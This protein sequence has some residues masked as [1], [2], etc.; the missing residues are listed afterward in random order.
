[1]QMLIY[2][3]IQST[4]HQRQRQLW[5]SALRILMCIFRRM[6]T[7]IRHN[8]AFAI[9]VRYDH[10]V[11]FFYKCPIRPATTYVKPHLPGAND[12]FV[13]IRSSA[14]ATRAGGVCSSANP[15][16][17]T[18]R[19]DLVVFLSSSVCAESHVLSISRACGA[20]S[21]ILQTY[22]NAWG[23]HEFANFII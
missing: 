5:L 17:N 21:R 8:T 20:A 7:P 9:I 16:H 10:A 3:P 22:A 12:T 11:I 2:W 6:K 14:D 23:C 15:H 4:Q 13:Q 18:L 1:M 19:T